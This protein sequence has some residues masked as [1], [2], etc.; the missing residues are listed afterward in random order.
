[1]KLTIHQELGIPETEII[2]NCAHMDARIHHLIAMI[3]QHSFS[4]TAYQ[5][6]KEF[7]LPLEQIYFI[8][9]VDGKTFL[10]LEKEV[11]FCR[12]TLA[13]LEEKLVHTSFIRIS[14]NCIINTNFL[15]SVR[16][17][18]NH[19]LEASLENGETLVVARNYIEALKNKLKGENL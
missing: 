15:K 11:Y 12:S 19:R 17:L 6:E 8:D 10:Y 3:R 13:V 14:K 1:M 9:S 5:E 7:Q 2:I 4:L 16:P 18:Y